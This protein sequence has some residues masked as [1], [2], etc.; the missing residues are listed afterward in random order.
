MS[1]HLNSG[2]Q[3]SEK[4]ECE[5]QEKSSLMETATC[6]ESG[7]K[8]VPIRRRGLFFSDSVFQDTRND[9]HKAIKEVLRNWGEESSIFDDLTSYRNLRSRDLREENQAVTSLEDE[10]YH[11]FVIDVHDFMNGGEISVKAV[12]E[13]ELVV[14]GHLEKKEDGSRSSKRFLRRFVVPGDIQLDAVTSVMSSDGVLTISAPKKKPTIVI[15]EVK[16]PMSIEEKGSKSHTQIED[17]IINSEEG[18]HEASSALTS[19]TKNQTKCEAHSVQETSTK[20]TSQ[21][22]SVDTASFASNESQTRKHIIPVHYEV[23]NESN[24]LEQLDRQHQ[25]TLKDN[26]VSDNAR[27]SE[28]EAKVSTASLASEGKRSSESSYL[29][30]IRKGLFSDDHFFENVRQNYSQAVKEVLE[31]ANEW[32]GERDAM[33]VYRNLRHDKIKNDKYKINILER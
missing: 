4:R 11:K 13:R 10:S 6:H 17:K 25:V 33:Q 2:R 28:C 1:T 27:K 5:C 21:S 3:S 9:F 24:S 16:V 26:Q 15:K 32:S 30:I 20:A 29:P 12:N 14:E 31:S 8:F 19:R 23:A 7:S 18:S 22:S